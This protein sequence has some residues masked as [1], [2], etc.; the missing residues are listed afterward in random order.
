MALD[1]YGSGR[2]IKANPPSAAAQKVPSLGA[3]VE[4][5]DAKVKAARE[6][7]GPQPL[8][9]GEVERDGAVLTRNVGHAARHGG[10]VAG[11]VAAHEALVVELAAVG[12]PE[13]AV[14]SAPKDGEPA[15]LPA[16]GGIKEAFAAGRCGKDGPL[17]LKPPKDLVGLGSKAC[18]IAA[19][20]Q[21]DSAL[22]IA[23]AGAKTRSAR[24]VRNEV[25]RLP[26]LNEGKALRPE[27][28]DRARL[29]ND[30]FLTPR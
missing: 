18:G 28:H 7:S 14:G 1:A 5:V 21:K 3:R 9:L 8:A 16:A 2:G 12:P 10:R 13:F 30:V 22:G 29:S 27:E 26:W 17:A 11:S 19:P 20:T 25:R 24:R 4:S 6:P 15:A 23:V